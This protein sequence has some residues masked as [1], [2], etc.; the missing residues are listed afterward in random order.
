MSSSLLGTELAEPQIDEIVAF[1][2]TLTG[3]QPQVVHP[4]LPVHAAETPQL[5]AQ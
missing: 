4:V 5:M 2:A 3:R 1:L